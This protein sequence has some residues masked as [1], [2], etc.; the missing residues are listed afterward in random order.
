MK[1]AIKDLQSMSKALLNGFLNSI[2]TGTEFFKG[3]E[4]GKYFD[5][6]KKDKHE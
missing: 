2:E 1:N 5:K 6:R 3:Y 4:R